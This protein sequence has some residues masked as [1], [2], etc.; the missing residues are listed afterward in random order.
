LKEK[1]VKWLDSFLKDP[2]KE[3]SGQIH[4][5]LSLYP[6]GGLLGFLFFLII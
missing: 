6:L 1:E 3:S 4:N 5:A 2:K